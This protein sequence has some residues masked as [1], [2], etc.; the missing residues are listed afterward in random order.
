MVWPILANPVV[1]VPKKKKKKPNHPRKTTQKNNIHTN[2]AQLA[3]LNK[4][5]L[6]LIPRAVLKAW[7]Y[8]SPS[9]LSPVFRR[10]IGCSFTKSPF[11]KTQRGQGLAEG[12]TA[13]MWQSRLSWI[14]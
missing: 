10:V 2:K 13:E 5:G 14:L 7:E 12:H 8:L 6:V 4:R 1:L 3:T 11:A 9:L